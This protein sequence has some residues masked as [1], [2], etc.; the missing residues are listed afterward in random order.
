MCGLILNSVYLY[1]LSFIHCISHGFQVK[2]KKIMRARD[3]RSDV[4]RGWRGMTP[5]QQMFVVSLY[6][7]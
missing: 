4:L 7:H 5:P 3:K 6:E 1:T 2:G